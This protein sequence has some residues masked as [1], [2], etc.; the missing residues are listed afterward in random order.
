MYDTI[1]LPV[2]GSDATATAIEGAIA[3]AERFESRLH[4]LHVAERWEL[5]ADVDEELLESMIRYGDVIVGDVEEQAIE[6]GLAV[7]T[8]VVESDEPTHEVI[9]D[10]A[11]KHDVDCVV[12]GTHGRTGAVRFALGSVTERTLRVS[13][14]PVI[15]VPTDG[16]L[17]P[18]FERI[19]VPTDGSE[20]A[21]AA[22]EH[23]IELAVAT[24]AAL[25]V[26]HVVDV[27]AVGFE[28]GSPG[29]LEALEES[30][31]NAIDEVV[32]RATG[33]DLEAVEATVLSG[34]TARAIL[35]YAE[36]RDVDCIVMGTHGRTGVG[37]LLL[38]SVA[39]RVVRLADIPVIGVKAADVVDSDTAK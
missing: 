1:L 26:V 30:G 2:D 28:G 35:D 33:A 20:G 23:A 17:D 36:E 19:L 31:R 5:P 16:V 34:T 3:V 12:M 6:A 7:T 22:A 37:R 15:T 13:P 9:V 39:E 27:G 10:Y 14:V 29:V 32:D 8:A 11:G 25:H 4:V 38:G 21:R 24:G 18:A